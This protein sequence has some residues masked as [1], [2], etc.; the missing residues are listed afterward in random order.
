MPGGSYMWGAFHPFVRVE[1]ILERPA[2]VDVQ[3]FPGFYEI[4]V[5]G[6]NGEKGL[7]RIPMQANNPRGMLVANFISCSIGFLQKVQTVGPLKAPMLTVDVV[8]RDPEVAATVSGV[9]SNTET[10]IGPPPL[11]LPSLDGPAAP[12]LLRRSPRL[13]A[14][15]APCRL[16]I[17]E[18]ATARK[19]MRMDA[20]GLG[21]SG[22]PVGLPAE[23]LLH[24]ADSIPS[25]LPRQ[26]VLQLAAECN[27]SAAQ[28]DEALIPV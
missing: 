21:R 17:L 20:M 13:Q 14:L 4:S 7:Y 22:L 28:I 5:L 19:R 12:P 9:V 23:D 26:D 27:I 18:K 24:L 6:Q 3:V 1:P 25:P 16:T 11:S 10:I 2:K 15:E 8:C